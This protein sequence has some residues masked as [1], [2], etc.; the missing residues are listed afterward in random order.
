MLSSISWY[1]LQQRVFQ[2]NIVNITPPPTTYPFIKSFYLL[3]IYIGRL[4]VPNIVHVYCFTGVKLKQLN[5]VHFLL[6][7]EGMFG[8]TLQSFA[9]QKQQ[10]SSQPPKE[11]NLMPVPSP[12]QIQYLN[13]FEGQEL[14]I[15]K[16]PNTSLRESDIMSPT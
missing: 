7:V 15:Q 4:I 14:T 16:Q 8:R 5:F 12:Q 6:S 1:Y 13:T 2:L 10:Q 3:C 11:P 9:Q